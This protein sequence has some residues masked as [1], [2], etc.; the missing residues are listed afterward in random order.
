M[1]KHN[2]TVKIIAR[3]IKIMA[4]GIVHPPKAYDTDELTNEKIAKK[5]KNKMAATNEMIGIYL[6]KQ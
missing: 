1:Y 3:M 4:N 6:G 5:S 2:M